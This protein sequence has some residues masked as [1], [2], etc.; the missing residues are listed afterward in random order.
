MTPR[1]SALAAFAVALVLTF[2][3][4]AQAPPDAEA[5]IAAQQEAME[6]IAFLDGEWRG[7][8]WTLTPSGEKELLTQ[9]ERVGSF[10]EGTVKLIEGRGY[11]QDGSLAFNAFAVVSYE[12]DGDTFTMR[13]HALGRA[14]DFEIVPTENGFTW[15][16]PAGPA[17]FRYT[18]TVKDGE[19]H[20]VGERIVEGQEP[21]QFFGMDLVRLGDTDWP[22]GGAVGAK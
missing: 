4:A 20:Q 8:A 2:P 5:R 19:W 14:G 18:A 11:A 10:A 22:A 6:R 17:S 1:R 9:T 7:T 15:E 12:P 3:A 13:S 16:I 21:L